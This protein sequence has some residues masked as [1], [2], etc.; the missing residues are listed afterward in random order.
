M[1]GSC[2][3]SDS[4]KF[5]DLA[6]K[7]LANWAQAVGVATTTTTSTS[8]VPIADMSCSIKTTG[9]PVDISFSTSSRHGTA[10]TST[11]FK[12]YING[13]AISQEFFFS[14]PLANYTETTTFRMIL[15]VSQGVHKV[16]AYWKTDTGT[17]T[18]DGQGRSLT[19]K[20]L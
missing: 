17:A 9:N 12:M 4:R 13:V 10:S 18:I 1:V 8:Y 19:V 16:D 7:P 20:E 14:A 5:T 11:Y 2:G 6:V 3:L 15:P